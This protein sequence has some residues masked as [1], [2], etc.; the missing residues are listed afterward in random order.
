MMI[1]LVKENAKATVAKWAADPK[2]AEVL[3]NF[4]KNNQDKSL[5]ILT[6]AAEWAA[7]H[8]KES[9]ETRLTAGLTVASNSIS[10]DYTGEKVLK[11]DFVDG[12]W[13][14]IDVFQ[15]STSKFSI[16][17]KP[18]GKEDETGVSLSYAVTDSVK[19]RGVVVNSSV[20]MLMGHAEQFIL[21]NTDI[22]AQPGSN[23]SFKNYLTKNL[24]VVKKALAEINSKENINIYL[25]ALGAAKNDLDQQIKIQDARQKLV[26]VTEKETSTDAEWVEATH[27]FIMAMTNAFRSSVKPPRSHDR[28]F[29]R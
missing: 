20:T 3:A 19:E 9:F 5:D 17:F 12:K 25:K 7:D 27:D 2:K 4:I 8:P 1:A 21:A 29:L 24:P 26:A 28:G 15:D 22:T 16:N 18:W 6:K 10:N 14:T 11:L 23:Q 13:A